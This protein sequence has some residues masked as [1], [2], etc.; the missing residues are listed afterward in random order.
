LL[1]CRNDLG[2]LAEELNPHN[3]EFLG[4]FPQTFSHL[5]LINSARMIYAH[6]KD[7]RSE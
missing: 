2:L 3:G 6:E 7:E 4:N 5:E 1:N